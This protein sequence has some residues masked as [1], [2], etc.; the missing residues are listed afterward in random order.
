VAAAGNGT[1]YN[2]DQFDNVPCTLNNV[3][4]VGAI[5][6]TTAAE[7]FSGYGRKVA[8]WAPDK[9]RTT[10]DRVSD[11][12]NAT[13]PL[14]FDELPEYDGTSLSSPFVAGIV[15]LMKVMEPDLSYAEVVTILQNTA[16]PSTDMKVSP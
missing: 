3:I 9:I 16:L 12:A 5:M 2:N 1:E 11:A 10:P 6:K 7:S 4:C 14:G 8:I 15:G 13:R